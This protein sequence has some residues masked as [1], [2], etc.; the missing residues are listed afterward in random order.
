ME[1]LLILIKAVAE[2]KMFFEENDYNKPTRDPRLYETI[3][4]NGAKMAR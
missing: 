4:V 1:H 2:N 3:L